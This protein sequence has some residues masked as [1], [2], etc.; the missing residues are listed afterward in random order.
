MWLTPII[1]NLTP[2]LFLPI[3]KTSTWKWEG[4][5]TCRPYGA[6]VGLVFSFPRAGVYTEQSERALGYRCVAPNGAWRGHARHGLKWNDLPKSGIVS[7]SRCFAITLHFG[8]VS[9]WYVMG[10]TARWRAVF[11]IGRILLLPL[12]KASGHAFQG[13]RYRGWLLHKT[14]QYFLRVGG[15][16]NFVWLAPSLFITSPQPSSFL[17]SGQALEK[18]R[19]RIQNIQTPKRLKK[20]YKNINIYPFWYFIWILGFY[21]VYLHE[22]SGRWRG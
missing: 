6:L 1:W 3:V 21:F 15:E 14:I 2:A 4:V 20:L 22:K 17:T 5:R 8:R 18:E 16:A 13:R 19:G 10:Q 9:F 7:A 12:R 11:F